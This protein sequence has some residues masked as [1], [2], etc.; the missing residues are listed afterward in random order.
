M[1][2]GEKLPSDKILAALEELSMWTNKRDR[3][4][5]ELKTAPADLRELKRMELSVAERHVKYYTALTRDMKLTTKPPKMGQ[6]M[7][8]LVIF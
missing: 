2:E 8:S 7:D 5:R 3:L 6:F 1:N 4:K